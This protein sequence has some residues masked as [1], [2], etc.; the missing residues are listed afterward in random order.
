M[1][2][3]LLLAA[4]SLAPAA[5]GQGLFD[6]NEARRRI[7]V[8]RQQVEAQKAATEAKYQQAGH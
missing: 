8:L 4:C 3:L 7:E 2:Y 1:R 6:D 5:L